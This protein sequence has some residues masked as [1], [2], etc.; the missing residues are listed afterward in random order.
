MIKAL[1]D[2]PVRTAGV[3]IPSK[4][5]KKKYFAI[6]LIKQQTSIIHFCYYKFDIMM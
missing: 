1:K 2:L 5:F 3:T 4:F 6:S